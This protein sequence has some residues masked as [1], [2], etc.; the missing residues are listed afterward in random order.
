MSHPA[1]EFHVFLKIHYKELRAGGAVPCSY[2]PGIPAGTCAR[3]ITTTPG[4]PSCSLPAANMGGPEQDGCWACRNKTRAPSVIREPQHR[5]AAHLHIC[6]QQSWESFLL[7]H[8]CQN[9]SC[10]CF[11]CFFQWMICC[12]FFFFFCFHF[13]A[14]PAENLF[15]MALKPHFWAGWGLLG[16]IL[17]LTDHLSC[18]WGCCAFGGCCSFWGCCSF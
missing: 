8:S 12:L 10:L 1:P 14:V 2:P 17:L 4:T 13:L 11:F 18:S 16:L 6:K 5:I 3:G 7:E 15:N 9:Y